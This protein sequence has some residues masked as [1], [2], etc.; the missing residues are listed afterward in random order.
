MNT[1][2]PVRSAC[3][4]LADFLLPLCQ[5]T[6]LFGCPSL[7]PT[8][9]YSQT[10]SQFNSQYVHFRQAVSQL[11]MVTAWPRNSTDMSQT[12]PR[13]GPEIAQKCPRYVPGMAQTWPRHGQGMAQTWP[14][15]GSDMVQT[16]PRHE[17]KMAQ[18]WHKPGL[19]MSQTLTIQVR[20]TVHTCPSHQ[21]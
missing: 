5:Q 20:N 19:A 6:F 18:T 10:I 21:V 16:W 11:D 2:L 15:H 4:Y 9:R 14:R 1:C 17:P 12:C 13:H 3:Q 8:L 7:L